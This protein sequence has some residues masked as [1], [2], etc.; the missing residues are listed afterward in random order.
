MYIPMKP[1]PRSGHHFSYPIGKK[2]NTYIHNKLQ[3]RLCPALLL[4]KGGTIFVGNYVCLYL[5]PKQSD[6]KLVVT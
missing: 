6:N 2:I 3:K 1:W 5:K 4:N